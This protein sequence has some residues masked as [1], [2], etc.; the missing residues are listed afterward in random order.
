MKIPIKDLPGLSQ[1]AR[2]YLSRF[3]KVENFFSADFRNWNEYKLL[4]KK[5]HTVSRPHADDLI[6]LLI[7]Q[8]KKFN[9]GAQ[10]LQ[11]IEQLRNKNALVVATGQQVG[12]FAG[13]LYTVYKALTTIKLAQEL[14]QRLHLPVLPLFYLVS[15]DHDFTEVQWAGVIDK[16]NHFANIR[17]EPSEKQDRMPVSQVI[18]DESINEKIDSFAEMLSETEFKKDIFNS[19]KTC[20]QPGIAFHTAFA[21]WFQKLFNRYGIILF[22]SADKRY[23]KYM[24]HIFE[25]ELAENITAKCLQKIG[26]AHV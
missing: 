7:E 9:C 4:A 6:A 11:N 22:D 2:D 24:Q 3:E 20:Y 17:Y 15:E 8:N 26:R 10:T 5:I 19:L 21:L 13:P 18:L 1:L 14:E 16:A 25:K 12:L 23:K